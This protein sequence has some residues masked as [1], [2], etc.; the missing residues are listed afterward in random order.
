MVWAM[1]PKRPFEII[2]T[3]RSSMR[4]LVLRLLNFIKAPKKLR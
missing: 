2:T 1:P 4:I 3:R